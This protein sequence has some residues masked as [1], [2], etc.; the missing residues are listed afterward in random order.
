MP[1]EIIEKNLER[2]ATLTREL[3]EYLGVPF[4]VFNTDAMRISAAERKFQLMVDIAADINTHILV[5]RGAETPDTYRRSFLDLGR[6]GIVPPKCAK[7]L[8]ESAG[9]RNILVHEYDF[10]EDYER[11]YRSAKTIIP[12]YERYCESISR[13]LKLSQTKR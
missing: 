4:S 2:L 10:E 11:F 7:K 6:A 1:N 12:W 5:S 3:K 13:Y 9:I 8:A